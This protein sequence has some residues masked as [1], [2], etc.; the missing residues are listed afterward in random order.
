MTNIAHK[1]PLFDLNYGKEEEHAVLE[2]L[3][4]KWISMGPNVHKLEEDFAKHLNIKHVVAV[5]NGTAAL[6]LALKTLDIKEGNEVIVP[7]LTFVA[8]VNAVRYVGATPVF[9]DITSYEDLSIDPTD[10]EKKI[11][12]RTKA[13][14]VMHYGGFAC[15]MD[16]VMKISKRYN[17]FVVEDV[18]HAPG[19][20]YKAKKLGTIGDIGCFSFFSNKNIACA[21]GGV[22]ATNTEEY[23]QK[24]RLLRSHGM[25]SLSYERA[26][27]HA[28]KYDVTALGYNYRMDDIR[29]ALALSQLKKLKADAEKRQKIRDRYLEELKHI[30]EVVIPYKNHPYKSSN[31]IFPIVLNNSNAK[32]RDRVR[33]RLAEAG[34]QTSVHYPAVHRFS[35]YKKF[36]TDLPKTDYV[37]D[38]EITLPLFF[39][40]NRQQ[41]RYTSS[42]LKEILSEN[43]NNNR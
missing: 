16:S 17:L 2:T 42:V 22:L 38:N 13:I 35:I 24:T 15:D 29:A 40:L 10:I 5:T 18:A 4:S 19:S 30:N 37:T 14:I 9:A 1:I 3:R 23:A 7:S 11:T 26:K 41:V 32:K 31:Y 12:P 6:H 28:T 34:I 36:A 25:T 33:K 39:N 8:T 27:G 43:N 21:E 20:E